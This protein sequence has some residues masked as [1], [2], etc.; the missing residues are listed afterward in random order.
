M[1]LGGGVGSPVRN[2]RNMDR[3][4][5]FGTFPGGGI[6]Y[7]TKEFERERL[8]GTNIIDLVPDCRVFIFGTEVTKDIKNVTITN[9]LRGNTCQLNLAN[10]RGKYEISKADLSGKWREDKDI[11]AIYEY[12]RFKR[13]QPMAPDMAKLLLGNKKYEQYQGARQTFFKGPGSDLPPFNS[14]RMIFETKFWSGIDKKVGD[15]VFDYRDPVMIFMKGRFSPYWYFAFT[16]VVVKWDDNDTYGTEQSINLFCEDVFFLLKKQ[17]FTQQ[18]SLLRAGYLDTATRTRFGNQAINIWKNVLGSPKHSSLQKVV[19]VLFYGTDYASKVKNC[20]PLYNEEMNKLVAL[21]KEYNDVTK[22]RGYLSNVFG[23]GKEATTF[24]LDKGSFMTTWGTNPD[25]QQ[26]VFSAEPSSSNLITLGELDTPMHNNQLNT[27]PFSQWQNFYPQLNAIPIDDYE[28]PKELQYKYISS[29]RYWEVR[30]KMSNNP[31]K[32]QTGWT[33]MG[34]IVGACGTHPALT[35]EFINHFEVLP[36]VWAQCYKYATGSS[37][38]NPMDRLNVSPH[39]KIL[40]LVSGSPTEQRPNLNS[41]TGT[42]INL[43][44]PRLFVITPQKFQNKNKAIIATAIG[45]LQLQ[46]E[47]TTTTYKALVEILDAIEFTAYCSPMGDVFIEPEMYDFHPQD[48]LLGPTPEA[49]GKIETRSPI[50]KQT[51]I[52]F[53]AI[54][55]ESDPEVKQVRTDKAFMYNTQAN[56]PFFLPEKD[57]I[58]CTQSFKPENIFTF[59]KVLPSVTKQG[60]AIVEKV[61]QDFMSRNTTVTY[62][63]PYDAKGEGVLRPAMYFADGFSKRLDREKMQIDKKYID[64]EI[65]ALE[66][67]YKKLLVSDLYDSNRNTP[68]EAF[69]KDSATAAWALT[70]DNYHQEKGWGTDRGTAAAGLTAFFKSEQTE[71]ATTTNEY[72][73]TQLDDI[74]MALIETM[75][76]TILTILYDKYQTSRS[77][78]LRKKYK[79]SNAK[80]IIG[81]TKTTPIGYWFGLKDIGSTYTAFTRLG[82]PSK[83]NP[84]QKTPRNIATDK[85]KAIQEELIVLYECI[86]LN[87]GGE[88]KTAFEAMQVKVAIRNG[89]YK[90]P[91]MLNLSDLKELEKAGIYNPRTDMIKKFGYNPGPTIKNLMIKSAQGEA[92]RYAVTKFNQLFGK[93]H[94]IHMEI[95]GRPELILNRPYYCEKKDAIGM[96]EKFSLNYN[97]GSDFQTSLDL[98]YIRRNSLTYGY[99]L[100]NLDELTSADGKKDNAFFKKAADAYYKSISD[101]NQ[102]LANMVQKKYGEAGGFIFSKAGS[103]LGLGETGQKLAGLLGEKAF[104][105]SGTGFAGALYSA[106]DWIGHMEYDKL[107]KT[108]NLADA[109]TEAIMKNT[110]LKLLVNAPEDADIIVRGVR[111]TCLSIRRELEILTDI[112]ITLD[113]ENEELKEIKEEIDEANK[114]L[115][116]ETVRTGEKKWKVQLQHKK[117]NGLIVRMDTILNNMSQY[118]K[119]HQQQCLLIYGMDGSYEVGLNY[120]AKESKGQRTPTEETLVHVAGFMEL[121]KSD[122]LYYKLIQILSFKFDIEKVSLIDDRTVG[123][124]KKGF[125]SNHVHKIGHRGYLPFYALLDSSASASASASASVGG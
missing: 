107:G 15:I 31:N 47:Q 38:A 6:V 35:Y 24:F 89:N 55:A 14:T 122:S 118:E 81:L 1:A 113:K 97:I 104:T 101:M 121:S 117:I 115:E 91:K 36:R 70:T 3:G 98:T 17:K 114:E 86:A 108:N 64:T 12:D 42:N 32:E 13:Q 83:A 69:L 61:F 77:G 16:G 49:V 88:L 75:C 23:I 10:P 116:G 96:L 72:G 11:L 78:K 105:L 29:V 112:E 92:D 20:H 4:V 7:D 48:F 119:L 40:E 66:D 120:D 90:F 52:K 94:A 33:D 60:M 57:R 62:A 2:K 18:G 109:T 125:E 65:K 87:A 19:Q 71:T 9:K 85:V 39:E 76:P 84:K 51:P 41:E 63:A 26:G 25:A 45:N 58:R 106:H 74:D 93:A 100:G 44:R 111:Q 73:L 103:K 27:L 54:L 5:V 79:Y 110:E 53:R 50:L 37:A 8:D 99:S 102:K 46:N 80:D 67:I 28:D 43:F 22:I 95:I 124:F 34:S 30:P 82:Q 68:L 59:I 123:T 56:H 21:K